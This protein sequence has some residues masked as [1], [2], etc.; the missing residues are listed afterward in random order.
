[1]SEII[2]SIKLE[3]AGKEIELTVGEAKEL[4][5]ALGEL[6]AQPQ[7]IIY[8]TYPTYPA[9]PYGGTWISAKDD[10]AHDKWKIT[11]TNDT[12]VQIN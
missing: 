10:P 4:H 12:G 5:A 7:P 8:P 11:Y 6:L 2:K 9:W 1:M 3:I